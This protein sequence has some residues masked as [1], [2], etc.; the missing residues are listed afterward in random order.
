MQMKSGNGAGP[1]QK[2]KATSLSQ[3]RGH[4]G[5]CLAPGRACPAVIFFPG[6]LGG[7]VTEHGRKL[8]C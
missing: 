4:V 1:D 3:R 2:G 8:H 5:S 7:P 6:L